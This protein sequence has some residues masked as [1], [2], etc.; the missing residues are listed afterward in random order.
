MHTVKYK[1][2]L[3]NSVCDVVTF[4]PNSVV[5]HYRSQT[6]ELFNDNYFAMLMAHINHD[7]SNIKDRKAYVYFDPENKIDP[8][9]NMYEMIRNFELTPIKLYDYIINNG[10]RNCVYVVNLIDLI[11]VY[12]NIVKETK[13]LNDGRTFAIRNDDLVNIQEI[14]RTSTTKFD[15]IEKTLWSRV[16]G[17]DLSRTDAIELTDNLGNISYE[18]LNNLTLYH[19]IED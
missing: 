2:R 13:L 5:T 10:W 14:D 11:Y 16:T 6:T 9:V 3:D 4:K 18:C 17:K 19:D 1:L 8:H 12:P 7:I 15:P